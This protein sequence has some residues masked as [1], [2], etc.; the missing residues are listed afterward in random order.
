MVQYL[1]NQIII[2]HVKIR[3]KKYYGYLLGTDLIDNIEQTTSGKSS[4]LESVLIIIDR[5]TIT[6]HFDELFIRLRIERLK[7]LDVLGFVAIVKLLVGDTSRAQTRT[8]LKQAFLFEPLDNEFYSIGSFRVRT[9]IAVKILEKKCLSRFVIQ[10]NSLLTAMLGC[11]ATSYAHLYIDMF[12]S[13]I[14]LSCLRHLR[15]ELL[16]Y[17]LALPSFLP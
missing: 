16:H 8:S 10:S 13:R 3:K 17:F 11:N 6:R 15:V 1:I 7:R 4:T 5:I 14:N 12:D 2:F 9:R